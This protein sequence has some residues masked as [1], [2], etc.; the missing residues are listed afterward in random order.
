MIAAP[1]RRRGVRLR[2]RAAG[3]LRLHHDAGLPPRHLPGRRRHPEP[4]AARAVHRQAGVRRHLLRVHRR[5]GARAPRGARASAP[6]TRRS[7][8]SRRSTSR[9]RSTTGRPPGSTSRRSCT[10]PSVGEQFAGQD[11]HRTTEQDHGLDKALDNELIAARRAGARARRAGARPAAV[12]NVNRTVG[13][14][15]GHEVTKRYGGDGLPDGTIDLT[16]TG[17]AGQSFGAF[18][19]RGITL[20]LE[21]DAND[22]VGKG[23]SGG[24]IVDPAGPRGDVRRRRADHRRQRHRLRRDLRRDLHPRRRRRAVL[25]PQLRRHRGR[26]GRGR[27][28]LRVHDRRPGRSS[29]ARPAATSRPACPAAWRTCS[30]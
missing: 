23:L 20:R 3:G 5:G 4:G 22:Y 13:T 9:R 28:R 7:A 25:R 24:R 8:T 10:C 2:H 1:A 21:G 29:S 15:L 27:P 16:F 6:S 11:L 18:L 17:S 14:M 26:R 30:T 12:R 19:P